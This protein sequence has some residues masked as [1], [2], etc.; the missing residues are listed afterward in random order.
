MI[1]NSKKFLST[2]T[3]K[4]VINKFLLRGDNNI[5]FEIKSKSGVYLNGLSS[6]QDEK[7]V[8][9]K[10]GA[11]FKVA[12]IEELSG[13]RKGLKITLQEIDAP[14]SKGLMAKAPEV[15][16]MLPKDFA[17]AQAELNSEKAFK[18]VIANEKGK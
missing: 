8:L 11:K 18:D 13:V 3:D 4:D 6:I 7:E 17:K 1:V 2:S 12:K 15:K 5:V 10:Y 16:S 9:F 14:I